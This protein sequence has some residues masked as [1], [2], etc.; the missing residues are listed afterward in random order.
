MAPTPD[1]VLNVF[2]LWGSWLVDPA[3]DNLSQ[4]NLGFGKCCPRFDLVKDEPLTPFRSP[5]GISFEILF[6]FIIICKC[7][8]N[9]WGYLALPLSS[10]FGGKIGQA[11]TWPPR[12]PGAH[13]GVSRGTLPRQHLAGS[14]RERVWVPLTW[15]VADLG[16]AMTSE[17]SSGVLTG[18]LLILPS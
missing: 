1:T 13:P 6:P 4:K 14:G 18:F 15:A 11:L 3:L 9:R 5:F 10:S 2:C 17:E 7:L 8:L 12:E 16:C